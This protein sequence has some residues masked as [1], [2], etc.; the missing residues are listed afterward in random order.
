MLRFPRGTVG[1]TRWVGFKG[2]H[3]AMSEDRYQFLLVLKSTLGQPIAFPGY[4]ARLSVVDDRCTIVKR[5]K[6]LVME[7]FVVSI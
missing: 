6:C 5:L 2:A 3:M 4:S 1:K 7:L